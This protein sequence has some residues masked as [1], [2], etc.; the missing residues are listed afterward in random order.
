MPELP[1]MQALAERLDAAVG[2]TTLDRYEL[3]GFSG[4]KTATPSPDVLVGRA[5][6]GVGRRGKFVVLG[7]DGGLRLAV[8]LSQAGRVDV[9]SPV[10]TTRP[11]G[12]VVRLVFRRPPASG[13]GQGGTSDGDAESETATTTIGL[14]VREHGTQRKAGWWVLASGDD[15][16]LG[17]LGPEPNDPAFADLVD[18]DDSNRRLHTWL[19]D[20]RVVAGVGRGYADDALNRAGLS[21]FA[22]LRG[23]DADQRTRLLAAV[24]SILEEGLERERQRSGGLSEN[25][26]GGGF[27]VHGRAG[28]P[29]PRCAEPLLRVSFDSYEIDYCKHCQTGGRA[30]A[31][32]RLSRLLR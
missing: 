16:P 24:R 10:K 19:R 32:R 11:R 2:G 8:H 28:E 4:L 29:C 26:L 3:L 31:D 1:Q 13:A 14:L 27:L 21:P 25:K 20:Q 7:F 30:L 15:G 5:V 9:E 17:A 12:S 6:T 22:S 18:H 23:L